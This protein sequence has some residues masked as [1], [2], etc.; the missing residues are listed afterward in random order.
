MK[1]IRRL[2]GR[3]RTDSPPASTTPD[4]SW[5]HLDLMDS[6]LAHLRDKGLRPASI[7][8]VGAAKGY[9]AQRAG[10]V[11]PDASLYM[12]DPLLESEASLRWLCE[13]EPRYHY[14][15]T[16]LGREPATLRINVS[17]DLDGSSLLDF[18]G[19]DQANQ[20]QVPVDS[21]DRLVAAGRLPVPEL[22]KLDVQGFELEVMEGAQSLLGRT[23]AFIVEVSFFEFMPNCPLAD[24]VIAYFTQRGYR[25]FD[26]AG[27]LRRPF[28]NDLGQ[29][30]F[31]FVSQASGL[32][33]D[34]RWA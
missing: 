34:R 10:A 6:A 15:L 23:A 33:E 21:V 29:M 19:Q 32:A 11:F 17:R 1:A 3:T 2:L 16:A 8:D 31:V 24:Q 4:V 26:V 22:V 9:W 20:R 27:L 5:T 14:F 25:L 7:L 13:R 18:P 30:D 12:I 28:Q